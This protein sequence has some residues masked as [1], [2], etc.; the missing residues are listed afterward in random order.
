MNKIKNKFDIC[1]KNLYIIIIN[2][3]INIS[4]FEKNN[5]TLIIYCNLDFLY[6]CV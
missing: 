3:I 6:K 1:L 2:I 5:I 4:F